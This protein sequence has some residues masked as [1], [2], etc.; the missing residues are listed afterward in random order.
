[1]LLIVLRRFVIQMDVFE[2]SRTSFPIECAFPVPL[3]S[4]PFVYGTLLWFP[5]TLLE[6]VCCR[7]RE[8]R[9]CFYGTWKLEDILWLDKNKIA[10]KV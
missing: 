4:S 3:P 10:L 9:D 7:S 1:M 6:N 8:I 2:E 5:Q